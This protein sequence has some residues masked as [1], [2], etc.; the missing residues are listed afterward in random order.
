M[1]QISLWKR[2]AEGVGSAALLVFKR[3]RP[4]FSVSTVV[5]AVSAEPHEYHECMKGD[6]R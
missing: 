6:Q 2:S 1:G 5:R 3:I 4:Q